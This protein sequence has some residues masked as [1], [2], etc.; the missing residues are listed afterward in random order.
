MKLYELKKLKLRG[1]MENINIKIGDR[2]LNFL[3][4]L[5]NIKQFDAISLW[6]V[7]DRP[8]Q[9]NKL[10]EQYLKFEERKNVI[11]KK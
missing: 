5:I 3:L 1:I 10:Y 4:Y 7:L 11:H 9:N 2:A 6:R 8:D